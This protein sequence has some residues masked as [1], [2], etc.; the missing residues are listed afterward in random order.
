MCNLWHINLIES[1]LTR[2]TT[3][4]PTLTKPLHCWF[5]LQPLNDSIYF[6][7]HCFHT[8]TLTLTHATIIFRGHMDGWVDVCLKSGKIASG[9]FRAFIQ[10]IALVCRLRSD[11]L[12][13]FCQSTDV[14]TCVLLF[15]FAFFLMLSFFLSLRH[16][17]CCSR[18]LVRV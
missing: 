5:K 11:S 3:N 14:F 8:P 1:N 18:V 17:C 4:Q 6:N 7:V 13:L 15:F 9:N 16:S 10:F 2:S 12:D